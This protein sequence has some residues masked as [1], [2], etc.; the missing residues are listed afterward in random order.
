[1]SLL[2]WP[3][4]GEAT[5]RLS[6]FQSHGSSRGLCLW[7][8]KCNCLAGELL[9]FGYEENMLQP[10]M[11]EWRRARGSGSRRVFGFL[12]RCHPHPGPAGTRC[13]SREAQTLTRTLRDAG[14]LPSA[15]LGHSRT[16][17]SVLDR[18]S[19]LQVTPEA[20]PESFKKDPWQI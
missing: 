13:R 4:S 18:L 6:V 9:R 1:M 14:T 11:S 8:V 12:I 2:L 5:A 3:S 17:W 15:P 20:T 16:N 10:S 19:S 7:T